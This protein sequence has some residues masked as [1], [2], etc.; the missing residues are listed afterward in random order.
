MQWSGS[1]I[2]N[3]SVT[4]DRLNNKSCLPG[5]IAETVIVT[6]EQPPAWLLLA[7]NQRGAEMKSVSGANIKPLELNARQVAK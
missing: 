7:P 3:L 4:S 2:R 6:D 5:G 1:E